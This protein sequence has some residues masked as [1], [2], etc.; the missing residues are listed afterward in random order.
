MQ[1]RRVPVLQA[2]NL[3]ADPDPAGDLRGG[4]LVPEVH[5]LL[6]VPAVRLPGRKAA[7]GRHRVDLHQP[8]CVHV[9]ISVRRLRGL[10]ARDRRT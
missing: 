10:L 2:I 6:R 7:G 4:A 5:P 9:A 8:R 1:Q 3:A